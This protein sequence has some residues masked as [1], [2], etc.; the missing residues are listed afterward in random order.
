MYQRIATTLFMLFWGTLV[1]A[2]AREGAG[3]SNLPTSQGAAGSGI[4]IYFSED[5]S[6]GTIPTDWT[7]ADPSGNNALWTHCA[8]PT[9]GQVNGCPAIWEDDL[10]AQ[11][12]FA[13]TTARNGFC[14]H[15]LRC[16][17]LTPIR[18]PQSTHHTQHR[19]VSRQSSG[20]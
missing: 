20:R 18:S 16:C 9:S 19:L 5:F 14:H 8:D 1:W 7:N 4:A 6:G 11:V 2:Q 12:P 15:G 10:N 3:F 13:A 17:W